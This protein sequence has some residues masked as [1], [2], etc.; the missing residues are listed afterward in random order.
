[1]K[2]SST[3][4]AAT[5]NVAAIAAP[6]LSRRCE[7]WAI[8]KGLGL[9]RRIKSRLPGSHNRPEFQ[10]HRY[11]GIPIEEFRSRLTRFQH[12]LGDRTPL[13]V[14]PVTATIYRLRVA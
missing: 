14:E 11:P 1:M 13:E 4:T 3:S 10:R 7:C 8:T 6:G 5:T 2:G 12:L 9:L